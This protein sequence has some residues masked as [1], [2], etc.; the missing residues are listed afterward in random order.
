MGRRLRILVQGVAA[1]LVLTAWS[2]SPANAAGYFPVNLYRNPS[3]ASSNARVIFY[4]EDSLAVEIWVTDEACDGYWVGT[5]VQV[6]KNGPDDYPGFAY[7][8]GHK[9]GYTD[10]DGAS[11]NYTYFDAKRVRLKV[12]KYNSDWKE[13]A[14]AYSGWQDNPYD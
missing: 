8:R 7:T 10:Y 11:A 3:W 6:G 2:V 1:L 4:D 9:C 14:C 12:C 5:T 13:I